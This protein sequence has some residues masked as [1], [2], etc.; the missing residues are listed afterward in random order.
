MRT[1]ASLRVTVGVR[2]VPLVDQLQG[3]PRRRRQVL[4]GRAEVGAHGQSV[5]DGLGET[6]QGHMAHLQAPA[7][8]GRLLDELVVTAR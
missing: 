4:A 8:L 6:G 5:H 7:E 1:T 2:T 3:E